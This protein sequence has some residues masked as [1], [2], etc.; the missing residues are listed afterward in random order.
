MQRTGRH[1]IITKKAHRCY[2]LFIVDLNIEKGWSRYGRKG[3]DSS[4]KRSIYSR[5][6]CNSLMLCNSTCSTALPRIYALV[7]RGAGGATLLNRSL[8]RKSINFGTTAN[9]VKDQC[10]T[11]TMVLQVCTSTRHQVAVWVGLHQK[12][13]KSGVG[14]WAPTVRWVI[15][16]RNDLPLMIYIKSKWSHHWESTHQP[17]SL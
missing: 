12:S 1:F 8:Q 9:V 14:D 3:H 16:H 6:F 2:T 13:G 4:E 7:T 17:K 10:G 5:V 11:S 15:H